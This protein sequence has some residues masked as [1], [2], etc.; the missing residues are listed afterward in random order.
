MRHEGPFFLFKSEKKTDEGQLKQMREAPRIYSFFF[1]GLNYDF[2]WPI[3]YH[4]LLKEQNFCIQLLFLA[5]LRRR[6]TG[7]LIGYPWIQRPSV[8]RP[9]FQTSSPL[10]PLGKSKPNFMWSLLGKGERKF[11]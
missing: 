10:K 4:V 5:H 9:H 7:E 2:N 1:F 6:L 3:T 8:R 11:I